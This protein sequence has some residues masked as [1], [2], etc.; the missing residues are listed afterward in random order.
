MKVLGIVCSPRKNGN[1]EILVKEALDSAHKLG[2]EIEMIKV[3]DVNIMP[4]DGCETCDITGE[5]KIEDDMQGIYT[6][7]LQSDGIIIG[8]PVYWLGVTAQAKIIIDRT[9][10]FRRGRR[11]RNKVAGAVVVARQVGASNA[12]SELNDFFGLHRM[13]PARSMGPRTEEELAKEW[14]G[15]VIAY[16]DKPGEVINNQQAMAR[17]QSLGV[18]M[19][20]TM[21]MVK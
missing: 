6:K 14:G 18:A 12:F 7:L 8:S 19:V 5:C 3:S 15:G 9:F 11:L 13:I 1:T 10:V 16:A 20:E 21:Q 17:A 2:A 4:C